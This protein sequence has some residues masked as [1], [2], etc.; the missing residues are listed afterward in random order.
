MAFADKKAAFAYV[1]EYQK[2]KYDRITVMAEKEKKKSTRWQL[3]QQD[4]HCLL[5]WRCV[6]TKKYQKNSLNV[7]F[8]RINKTNKIPRLITGGDLLY[9]IFICICYHLY[10]R[11]LCC[12]CILWY[13]SANINSFWSTNNDIFNIILLS[14][15]LPP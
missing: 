4:C 8:K 7:L 1:N 14:W 6:L 2:E 13:F 5:L 11:D 10:G 9:I 3:K 12:I 15:V